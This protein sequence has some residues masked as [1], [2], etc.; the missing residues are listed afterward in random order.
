MANGDVEAPPSGESEQPSES[1]LL[2]S[3]WLPELATFEQSLLIRTD[4]DEAEL[5]LVQ[6]R[7]ISAPSGSVA[8]AAHRSAW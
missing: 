7:A 1:L 3:G 4:S 2:S 5:N 8:I 6:E